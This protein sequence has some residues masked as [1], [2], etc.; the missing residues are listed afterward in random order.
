[1]SSRAGD[2]AAEELSG[3][4]RFR[5]H[6]D[7]VGSLKQ[8]SAQCAEICAGAELLITPLLSMWI[9]RSPS[10]ERAL[11]ALRLSDVAT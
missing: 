8:L 6:A 10:D 3:I 5:F 7:K 2:P 4:A 9:L 1:V 11:Q